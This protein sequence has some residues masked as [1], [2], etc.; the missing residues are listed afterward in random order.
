MKTSSKTLLALTAAA[1]FG[2]FAATSLN[3]LLDQPA[4]AEPAPSVATLP[5]AGSLPNV[6]NGTPMPSLAPMLKRVLP[7]VVSVNT[8]QRVRVNTPFGD[9]PVFR[10]MFG[11]PQER[12][13]QSLGSGV[14]VDATRGLVLTNNH[15]VED[16]DEVSVTLADGR[17]L[18]AEFVGN[19]ADTDIALMRIPAQNLTAIPVA[20]S[21]QLQIGDFVV[22]VGNP[23]G[24]GQTVTSGIVSA[25]G[26]NN[27][28]G[29]GFQ[30]FIQTDASINPGHSGGAMVTLNGDQGTAQRAGGA[31]ALDD[32]RLGAVTV[33]MAIEGAF[34]DGPN[35]GDVAGLFGADLHLGDVDPVALDH[36]VGQERLAHPLDLGLDVVTGI[37]ELDQLADA[38]VGDAAPS[39]TF[40]R[41][42]D[43][44][45]LNVEDARLEEDVN[46]DLGHQCSPP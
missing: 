14:I 30:N 26:R 32:G 10:R 42:L 8:K 13:A 40:Q 23:F 37:V 43:G 24:V 17:T 20:N 31:Q 36:G 9:D 11:I 12:I 28:P 7:A 15:V 27:L 25:V 3:Y 2:G 45:T 44:L 5:A 46:L 22:A 38:D 16:A 39:Q 33:R 21:D 19:D 34:G 1:A 35:G 29:A 4:S 18:K 41:A 6:V